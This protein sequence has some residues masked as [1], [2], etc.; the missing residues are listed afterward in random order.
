MMYI[1]FILLLGPR[2]HNLNRIDT[3][4]FNRYISSFTGDTVG[5]KQPCLTV[6]VTC[7]GYVNNYLIYF[8]LLL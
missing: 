3:C 5:C 2:A 8:A 7:N 4:S 1:L 6:A